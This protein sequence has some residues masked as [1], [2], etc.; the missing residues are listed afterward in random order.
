M[1][2]SGGLTI[3]GLLCEGNFD[4]WLPRM[5]AILWQY[6]CT[7]EANLSGLLRVRWV[8]WF[9]NPGTAKEVATII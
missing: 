1:P 4:E 7:T 2:H 6:G 3:S 8:D 5:R 9:S